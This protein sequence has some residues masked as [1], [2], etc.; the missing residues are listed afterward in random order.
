MNQWRD[1]AARRLN[2]LWYS[3]SA[4]RWL[5]W[6]VAL[7]FQLLVALR[8]MA[9]ARGLLPSQSV[10][11]P[12]VVVGNITVGG[13]GK[14]PLTIWLARRLT[15]RGYRVGI[16]CRGYQGAAESWPQ[17]VDTTTDA[18]LVGDEARLLVDR[19]GCP[20]AAG[21]NRVTA[22]RALLGAGK[23]DVILV[24]D[25]LQHY[26]LQRDFEI[27]VIDGTRGLGN[28]L[29]LPAGPLRE[30]PSRL[31]E[32]DAIVVNQGEFGHGGV[33]RAEVRAVRVASLLDGSERPLSAFAGQRVHAV[34]AIGN[35][36]RFFDLLEDA[37]L[38]V[39]P[40]AHADHAV[41]TDTDLS[42]RDDVPVLL[43]EKDAVKCS[44]LR[45]DKLWKV[46][47]DLEFLQGDDERLLRTLVRTLD[48]RKIQ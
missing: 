22:A 19:T 2:V 38:D 15:E 41:L 14:T 7:L 44:Q 25:G 31:R 36:A 39:I 40:H 30:P 27:A 42:F 23:V 5:L 6:P 28:G 48:Q 26:R 35:P 3:D 29:C 37:G 46:E 12:V 8:R 21:P 1:H 18:I 32:V 20:V 33:L 24:D 11:V 13:T 16:V 43:T 17:L 47:A 4:L 10:G 34:A 45:Q 9:Y